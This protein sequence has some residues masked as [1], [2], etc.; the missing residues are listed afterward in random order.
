MEP[1][2][3]KPMVLLDRLPRLLE[4]LK[5]TR[6]LRWRFDPIVTLE[7]EDGT[8]WTSAIYFEGLA[9]EMAK[10]GI[11]N[12]YFSFCEIYPKFRKRHLEKAGIKIVKPPIEE[13]FNI[14]DKMRVVAERFG[15]I[16][17]SCAQPQLEQIPGIT[18]AKCIDAELLT[19][20][21]PQGL[22][23]DQRRDDIQ[24]KFRPACYCTKSQDIGAY[25]PCG[26]GCVYCYAEP[27][28]PKLESCSIIAMIIRAFTL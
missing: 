10:F 27:A 3:P 7:K 15:I 26:H 2:V 11:D 24:Q 16:L 14:V 5:D 20:L 1:T 19:Q 18:A 4:S 17:Y 25:L 22:S 12:C 9:T 13:Q 6:R 8:Q 23:A 28:V 21:H